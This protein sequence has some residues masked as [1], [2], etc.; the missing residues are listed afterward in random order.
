MTSEPQQTKIWAETVCPFC[1][2]QFPAGHLT[3]EYPFCSVCYSE[4]ATISVERVDHF[5]ASH[6]P[7]DMDEIVREWEQAS[8]YYPDFKASVIQRIGELREL[9]I[10]APE[11]DLGRTRKERPALSTILLA[12]FLFSFVV[13]GLALVSP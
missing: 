7:E 4:G 1:F 12:V 9:M 2:I 10:S 6:S 3:Y 8:G 13:G 5:I 11:G